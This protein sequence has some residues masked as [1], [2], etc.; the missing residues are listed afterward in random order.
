M[1][2]K[3]I[4]RRSP[5]ITGSDSSPTSGTAS[6]RGAVG[7]GRSVGIL[8]GLCSDTRRSQVFLNLWASTCGLRS[9]IDAATRERKIRKS[10]VLQSPQPPRR[11]QI[12]ELRRSQF[13]GSPK[14]CDATAGMCGGLS[15]HHVLFDG[16]HHSGSSLTVMFR[17]Q[18]LR[19][20]IAAVLAATP[21]RRARRK[22]QSKL[23]A[24][25]TVVRCQLNQ[26]A[27]QMTG[28]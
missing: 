9:L 12:R 10:H 14:I 11:H 17:C 15:E 21:K 24:P 27:C 23:V 4:K 2:M 16:S 25:S 22:P 19:L 8:R 6:H 13:V 1:N 18:Y 7:S 28:I 5:R 20:R 26:T 3:C